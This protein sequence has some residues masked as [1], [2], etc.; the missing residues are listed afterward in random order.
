M[1]AAPRRLRSGLLILSFAAAA[2][3]PATLANEP[4][5][6]A[7]AKSVPGAMAELAGQARA[8]EPVAQY[9]YALALQA[10]LAAGE[11]AEALTWMRAAAEAGLPAARRQL[12]SW[13]YG[14]ELAPPDRSAA[15]A[16]WRRS[17]AAGDA[18]AQYNA[19]V[20]LLREDASQQAARTARDWLEAAAAAGRHEAQLALAMLLAERFPET[21]KARIEAL[22]ERAA[23]AGYRP[24]KRNLGVLIASDFLPPPAAPAAE[25][26]ARPQPAAGAQ[27]P[28]G[29][30]APERPTGVE[31]ILAQ[32]P[33]H[34]TIQLAT[35]RNRGDLERML[36]AESLGHEGAWF[37]V[38]GT[39]RAR[40]SAVLGA[41]AEYEE[42][43]RVLARL[44]ER[45]Q[46]HDPWIRRF[47]ELQRL[48]R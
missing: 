6:A 28:P 48:L 20:V 7:L 35:G 9:G 23:A 30:G 46:A 45:M 41:F 47:E 10:G 13:L 3:P 34:F 14:G 32:E 21:P 44:S 33:R 11:P 18:L 27:A 29:P 25:P 1:S 15:L 4:L 12:A 5:L 36:E 2:A 19:A 38:P 24:A 39:G 26:G 43:E 37:R 40:Y 42:A 16:W 8:G 22:L 31:W 17:A